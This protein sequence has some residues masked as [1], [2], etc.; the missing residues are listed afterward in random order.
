[1]N[2]T[3]PSRRLIQWK[4]RLSELDFE[5]KY[6]KGNSNSQADALSRLLAEGETFD[7]IDD[8]IPCFMAKTADATEEEDFEWLDDI[9]ALE[10][11]ASDRHD[12]FQAV[13]PEELFREQAVD[14]SAVESRNIW[15]LRKQERSQRRP[16][17]SKELYVV[18]RQSLCKC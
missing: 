8:E 4:L 10:G 18:Q 1:M 2:A 13:V 6:K 11:A 7:A 16:R 14:P 12:H 9:L 3:D 5:I 17:S 15:T